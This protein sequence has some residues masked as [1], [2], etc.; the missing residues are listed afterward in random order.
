[1]KQNAFLISPKTGEPIWNGSIVEN[2]QRTGEYDQYPPAINTYVPSGTMFS[3]YGLRY[4]QPN[5][6]NGIGAGHGYEATEGFADRTTGIAGESTAI[7]NLDYPQNFATSGIWQRYGFDS[8]IQAANDNPYW[9]NPA[10][11]PTEGV[12]LFG[13]SYLPEGVQ[14]LYD[15]SYSNDGFT[16]SGVLV[17]GSTYTAASGSL[18]FSSVTPGS[19]L[20][21]RLDLNVEVQTIG[22]TLEV[23]LIW[24]LRDD[25]DNPAGTIVLPGQPITFGSDSVGRTFFMRPV[26][27]AYFAGYS[28]VNA[29]ALFAIRSN[30]PVKTQPISTLCIINK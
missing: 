6:Y 16:P 24:Q 28:D 7:S 4:N 22:T 10:P 17:D 26:I 8:A 1:M 23:A 5:Y 3:S 25:D 21:A 9:T 19:L 2:S 14:G 27:T 15:F 20:Q 11:R 29:R 30:N 18:D 12:G 13:G